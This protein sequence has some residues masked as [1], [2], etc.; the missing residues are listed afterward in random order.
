MI[1]FKE[2]GS[3]HFNTLLYEFDNSE[4]DPDSALLITG[5][6]KTSTQISLKRLNRKK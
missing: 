6:Q 1:K 5:F 3:S 2:L 4:E